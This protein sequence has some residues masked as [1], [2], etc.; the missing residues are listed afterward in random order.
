MTTSHHSSSKKFEDQYSIADKIEFETVNESS[1]I[2]KKK[3]CK[4]HTVTSDNC[5][6]AF[7][8]SMEIPCR[9][10]FRFLMDKNLETYRPD[11][12]AKRWTKEY[13]YGSHPAINGPVI[14]HPRPIHIAKVLT[15]DEKNKYK[16]AA[17]V[18]KDITSLVSNMSNSQFEFYMEAMDGFKSRLMREFGHNPSITEGSSHEA[19]EGSRHEPVDET[20]GIEYSHKKHSNS[21]L[22][23]R[24]NIYRSRTSNSILQ[25]SSTA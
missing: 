4:G 14:S 19:T 16:K 13:F 21:M 12:C 9:H 18:T 5:T 3:N 2:T 11:I 6:C 22:L 1:A 8:A 17:A 7:F 25:T 15:L 23:Y 24:R 20:E 10:I